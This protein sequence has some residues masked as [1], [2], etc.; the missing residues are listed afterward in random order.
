MDDVLLG[1][2]ANIERC[3]KRV[4][5]K[6]VGHEAEL[7]RDYDLQDIV[8]LNL[9]RACE[10]SIDGAMHL[11]RVRRLGVPR[12]AAEGFLLLAREGLLGHDLAQGLK[13]VVGF[14]NVVVHAYTDIDIERL[15]LVL[16][17]GVHELKDFASFLVAQADNSVGP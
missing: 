2:A 12:D 15:E 8:V 1:K 3:L 7:A 5:D 10:A 9:Q 13:K 11:V 14:R 6:Y 4:A 16:R 17:Y